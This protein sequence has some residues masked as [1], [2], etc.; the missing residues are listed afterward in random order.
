MLDSDLFSFFSFDTG[1]DVSECP[2]CGCAVLESVSVSVACL[3]LVDLTSAKSTALRPD[4]MRN[5]ATHIPDLLD[6]EIR[7]RGNTRIAPSTTCS[8]INNDHHGSRAKSLEQL[9]DFQIRGAQ[10]RASVVETYW[11]FF[12]CRVSAYPSALSPVEFSEA[13]ILGLEGR[14]MKVRGQR[15]A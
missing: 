11:A 1:W 4:W 15:E 3:R 9:G 5:A 6:R 12:G 10:A 7:I 13:G 8:H 2:L 14:E